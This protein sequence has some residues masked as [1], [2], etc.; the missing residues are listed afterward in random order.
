M[1]VDLMKGTLVI[2]LFAVMN[3]SQAAEDKVKYSVKITD[4]AHHM[5][6]ITVLF[7]Q[8]ESRTIDFIMPAWRLGKYQILNLANGIR[9]FKVTDVRGNEVKSHRID[10]NSWRVSLDK[11]TKLAVSYELYANQLSSRT[12]HID[13]THAYLDG[14]ITFRPGRSW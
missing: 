9:H 10:K 12:R 1:K 6:E 14:V 2:I 11:P 3:I 4:A 7:P 8:T 5:A 13:D